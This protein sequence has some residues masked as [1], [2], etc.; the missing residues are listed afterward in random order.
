M[1][2][3]RPVVTL[4]IAPRSPLDGDKLAEALRKVALEDPT[5]QRRTDP[6]TDEVVISGMGELH[7][8]VILSVLES[9]HGVPVLA[10]APRSLTGRRSPRAVDVEGRHG[11][12][13]APAAT[14][15]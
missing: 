3:A 8:E 2:F 10:K 14:R 6:E 15:S 4:A 9:E 13:A 7:L 5:F 12:W 1:S 11:I